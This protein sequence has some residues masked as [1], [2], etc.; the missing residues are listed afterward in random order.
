[1]VNASDEKTAIA[2]LIEEAK[3]RK[4]SYSHLNEAAKVEGTTWIESEGKK[5]DQSTD[6]IKNKILSKFLDDT[7]KVSR[8]SNSALKKVLS[9]FISSQTKSNGSSSSSSNNKN[10]TLEKETF[11]NFLTKMSNV[12]SSSK[13]TSSSNTTGQPLPSNNTLKD[14]LKDSKRIGN[15]SSRD[16][17][18]SNESFGTINLSELISNSTNGNVVETESLRKIVSELKYLDKGEHLDIYDLMLQNL[19]KDSKYIVGLDAFLTQSAVWNKQPL[20]KIDVSTE[21]IRT[22]FVIENDIKIENPELPDTDVY[23]DNALNNVGKVIRLGR[24]SKFLNKMDGIYKVDRTSGKVY[25]LPNWAYKSA[26]NSMD[27]KVKQLNRLSRQTAKSPLPGD[28]KEVD[29]HVENLIALLNFEA[30]SETDEK[31]GFF[32]GGMTKD[33]VSQLRDAYISSKSNGQYDSIAKNTIMSANRY[34]LIT[35]NVGIM[36]NPLVLPSITL[37][38]Y[39]YSEKPLATTHGTYG[40]VGSIREKFYHKVYNTSVEALL[41]RAPDFRK[42]MYHGI[43]I[44]TTPDGV[45]QIQDFNDLSNS[46]N[47]YTEDETIGFTTTGENKNLITQLSTA[48]ENILKTYYVR[49]GG[50]QIPNISIEPVTSSFLNREFKRVSSNFK[51]AH[52]AT[53]DFTVDELGLIVRNFNILTGQ[54]GF[55]VDNEKNNKYASTLF[56][57]E[58]TTENQGRLD[59]VVTYNDFRINPNYRNI[60]TPSKSN[61]YPS[62]QRLESESDMV[63][64]RNGK[65]VYGD[66]RSYRQ[67]VFEDVKILGFDGNLSFNRESAS[68]SSVST[69]I[70]FKR[71]TTVDNNITR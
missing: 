38:N 31:E 17:S 58:F 16:G 19:N 15:S 55:I 3:K 37:G 41:R 69:K 66:Q 57:V 26:L 5:L 29:K 30:S 49:M 50:I 70:V 6:P 65:Q 33:E 8:D 51:E 28:R 59:L 53:I 2:E 47:G 14:F 62:M 45:G 35:Y 24:V 63:E 56:P 32:Q 11:N 42:N 48:Y 34:G 25:N 43:F 36:G 44:Y 13:S 67:F 71:I 60:D 20:E 40:A 1:M 18:N 22:N 4:V 68:T 46:I 27:L 61:F 21:I 23:L 12:S 54:F 9:D 52:T 7:S 39:N 64:N 10:T